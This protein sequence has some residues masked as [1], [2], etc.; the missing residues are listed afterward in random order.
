MKTELA[1]Q[2]FMISR[3][4]TRNKTQTTYLKHLRLF[5]ESFLTLPQTP[6]PIQAWLN[7]SKRLRGN[8][9]EPL[10]PET[11][12][13]RFRTLRAF[14]KQIHLWH[15]NVKDPMP[16][17][18][19]PSMKPKAM[20]TFTEKELYI[21]FML[22]LSL[23]DKT[24]CTFLLGSGVRA[25]ECADLK[26]DDVYPEYVTVKGKTGERDVPITDS[27]YTLL[28]RLRAQNGSDTYV[29]TGKRGKLTY[30]GIYKIVRRACRLAGISGSRCSPHTFRHTFGTEYASSGACD[31][32][33]LQDILGHADFKTT[34]RYIQNNRKRNIANHKLCNPLRLIPG[35]I[36][37]HLLAVNE[38]EV[39]LY[40][41]CL[42]TK[43]D[44]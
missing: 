35:A 31:P 29:F 17:V 11:I 42:E 3:G 2:E 7:S 36:Q 27:T 16:L 30:E 38:A 5:Q 32:K 33:S 18:R 15:K 9:N 14:Y 28:T 22:P 34:L 23:R 10:T 20:R 41:N 25:Q 37:G 39:I 4:G 44:E 24:V 8:M 21:I 40:N 19:P 43:R 13:S 26:W 6:Q 12:H 1:V